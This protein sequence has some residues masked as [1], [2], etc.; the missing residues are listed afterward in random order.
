VWLTAC[1]IAEK[2]FEA[3]EREKQTNTTRALTTHPDSL[4]ASLGMIFYFTKLI[5][6]IAIGWGAGVAHSL[7]SYVTLLWEYAGPASYFSN[8]CTVNLFTISG[9]HISPSIPITS[10][11]I[12]TAIQSQCF[13]LLHMF[14]SILSF[15]S[16]KERNW[17]KIAVI[18]L[19]HLAA[20]FTVTSFDT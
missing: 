14:W 1:R 19:S 2:G 17:I 16:F 4:K 20:S 7:V 15:E 13:I 5:K 9:V 11:L 6:K 18:V 12:F 3:E 8:N 10:I